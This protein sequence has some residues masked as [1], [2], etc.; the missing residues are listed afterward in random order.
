MTLLLAKKVIILAKFSNFADLFSEKSAN[1]FLEQIRVNQYAIKLEEGKQPPYGPI[2]I[3]GSIKLKT[4]KTYIKTNLANGFIKA[5]NSLAVAII[6]VLY[7]LDG[8][9]CLCDNCQGL[10][11]LI[12][13]N[14]YPLPLI[15]KF[16]DWLNQTK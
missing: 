7:K 16:L 1:I 10:N 13:K 11:N 5:S 9:L 4:L 8:S 2:Y 3:L 6:L 14:W 15:G 12:I